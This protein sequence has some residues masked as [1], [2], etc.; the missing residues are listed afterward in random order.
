[1][2]TINDF[3]SRNRGSS[4]IRAFGSD[5]EMA[6]WYDRMAYHQGEPVKALCKT[7]PCVMARRRSVT[8]FNRRRIDHYDSYEVP[9]PPIGREVVSRVITTPIGNTCLVYERHSNIGPSS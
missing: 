2:P 9:R 5:M 3:Q 8:H 1:M 4:F 6:D 7:E